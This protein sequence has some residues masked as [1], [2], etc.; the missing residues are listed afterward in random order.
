M[1]HFQGALNGRAPELVCMRTYLLWLVLQAIY[2]IYQQPCI[3]IV[4]G[5]LQTH[6]YKWSQNHHQ[7]GYST[8]H[9]EWRYH[10]HQPL[11]NN[12][13]ESYV[14]PGTNHQRAVS[15]NQ[16][17]FAMTHLGATPVICFN[18][19]TVFLVDCLIDHYD[20]WPA[21]RCIVCLNRGYDC[22][23]IDDSR[24]P[25]NGHTL[26]LPTPVEPRGLAM[27]LGY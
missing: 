1:S 4:T 12:Q 7:N 5:Y 15:M 10:T 22:W 24:S 21:L 18:R 13:Q 11:G 9:N 23:F 25:W 2:R 27:N 6:T 26:N 3:S 17:P 19:W 8:K 20:P 14:V 16:S